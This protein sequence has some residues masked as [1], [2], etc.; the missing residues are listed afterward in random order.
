M[1]TVLAAIASVG[2]IVGA[3]YG[4][5]KWVVWQAKKTEDQLNQSIDQKVKSDSDKEQ[6]TGRPA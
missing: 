6:S 3:V 4:I 5:F 2:G 1:N